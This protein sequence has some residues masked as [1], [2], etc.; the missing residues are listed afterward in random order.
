M[1]LRQKEFERAEVNGST[2][3]VRPLPLRLLSFCFLA[4]FAFATAVS[5]Q[6]PPNWQAQVRTYCETRDWPSAIRILDAEITRTPKD[7]DLKAWRARILTWAGRL[8]EAEQGYCEILAVDRRDPDNWAGLAAVCL[9]EGKNEEALR[10]VEVAVQIDPKRADLHAAYARILRAAAQ[11]SEARA[12][13]EKALSLDPASAEARAGLITLR[14]QPKNEIRGGIESDSLSYTV[15]NHAQSVSL[16]TRWTPLWSTDIGASFYQ[17][18]GIL[19]EKF[20]GSLTARAPSFATITAGGAIANDNAVIPKS[21]AFFDFDRGLTNH[22]AQILK[23]VEFQYGQHWYW[24]QTARILT[25]N[26]TAILYLPRDWS[27]TLGATGARSAFS[28][29]GAEW[30]PSGVARLGFPLVAWSTARLSGNILFAAGAENFASTDQIGRFASQ[31][32]GGGVR[33]EY[34]SRWFAAFTYSYQRRTQNRTD[35]YTGFSYGYRF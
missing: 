3:S 5:A 24:Y 28:S 16:I 2:F 21:E 18:S 17:R 4:L 32:Y 14:G 35:S 26:G 13:F 9:R 23:G 7:L 31:T 22:D 12:E 6:D 15:P 19:A 25:L 1:S 30:R 11:R 20:V 29:I 33:F 10:A 34:S 8:E 27:L